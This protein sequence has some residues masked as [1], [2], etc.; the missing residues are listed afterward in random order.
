MFANTLKE[1]RSERGMTQKQLA[2]EINMSQQAVAKWE[3]GKAEPSYEMTMRLA[4]LFGVSVDYLMAGNSQKQKKPTGNA[5][6]DELVEDPLDAEL[7]SAFY[8]LSPDDQ[9]FFLDMMRRKSST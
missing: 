5:T 6:P 1:L 7:R 2:S 8:S 3:T 9:K 4:D